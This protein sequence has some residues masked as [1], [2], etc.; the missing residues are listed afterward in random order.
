MSAKT[1]LTLLAIMIF[2]TGVFCVYLYFS[3]K[4]MAKGA[5]MP[6]AVNENVAEKE[7]SKS[8]KPVDEYQTQQEILKKLDEFRK[9]VKES[10]TEKASSST[11]DKTSGSVP[12]K[13]MSLEE[14]QAQI[15]SDLEKFRKIVNSVKN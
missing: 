8:A 6:P 11:V 4:P 5:I 7:E 9:T 1:A 14:K 15:L 12:P 2:V 13:E 10:S 3:V